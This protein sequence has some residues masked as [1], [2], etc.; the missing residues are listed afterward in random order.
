MAKSIA[1]I[2]AGVAGLSA[3]CYGQMN[4]YKTTIFEMH[5]KP[6]GLCTAWQRKGYTIDGCLHWLV[7]SAP[8]VGLYNIWNELGVLQG[9]QVIDMD[10]FYR[11]E[12]KDGNVFDL[13]C[14]IDRLEQHMKEIAPEDS[15]FIRECTSTMRRLTRLDMPADK[16]P[17]LY[18]PF[19]GLKL[20]FKML[21]YFRDFRKWGRMTMRDLG[22]RFKN[23][24]L[25]NAWNMIWFS[26]FSSIFMLI[27]IAWLHNKQAGYIVGGSMKISRAM[28]KRYQEL[29]GE[30]HYKSRVTDI[31]L[32]NDRAVGIKLEDGTEHKADYVVSAADGHFTIF[33]LLRGK[34][35]DDRILGYYDKLLVFPPLIYVGLGVNRSFDDMPQIISGLTFGLEEPVTIA[36]EERNWLSVRVHNFDPTLAPAGKTVL[37]VMI[38][39]NYPY[40][41]SLHEDLQLY[42]EEKE[43]IA[44]SAR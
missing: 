14:N 30:I 24:L 36:G 37:T 22:M 19:D 35:V 41:K 34:Y 39:S 7:G 40:W 27:T 42:K 17:E 43:R 5:D 13:H 44:A 26:E 25:R 4:G 12:D 38:E 28:E 10:R 32:E 20:M 8:G 31:L 16:A 18:N 15:K 29:G 6:G 21:P 33:E 2:G 3:G 11:V 1:I 23:P 9:Q